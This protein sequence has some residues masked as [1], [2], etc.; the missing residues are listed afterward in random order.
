MRASIGLE[1]RR[2]LGAGQM[3]DFEDDRDML[4]R[5]RHEIGRIGDL[6]H[7]GAVLAQRRRKLEPGPGRPVVEHPPQDK[8][9]AGDIAVAA[10]GGLFAC[11]VRHV[12][13]LEPAFAMAALSRATV[14]GATERL[15][16]PVASSAVVRRVA[17]AAS[18]QSDTSTSRLR[19]ASTVRAISASTAGLPASL[20]SA[21][22][23]ISRAAAIVY[24]VRS[25][26]PM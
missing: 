26:D 2:T 20:R 3:A 14:T 17:A 8:L 24:W 21:T 23:P 12:P 15:V 11:L 9:V 16:S 5:D 22:E 7:E 10:P 6:G 1:E 19:A 4:R 13:T 25:F 18:P